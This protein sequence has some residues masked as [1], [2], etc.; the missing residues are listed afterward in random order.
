[1]PW[2]VGGIGLARRSGLLLIVAL[3]LFLFGQTSLLAVE[4]SPDERQASPTVPAKFAVLAFR[5]KPETI[6]RW[7]PIVDYLNQAG[8]SRRIELA[9]YTYKE[10]E[11][12]VA[13]KEVDFVLTQPS[14]YIILTYAQGLHSPL[15]TLVEID[16]GQEMR[17]FGGVIVTRADRE[18]L[19]SL[20]DLR[21]KKLVTSAK[22][23]LGSYQM[24][25]GEM[26]RR[27]I[28]VV[29]EMQV[30]EIGQP[31]DKSIKAVLSGEADVAFVRTGL[32]ESMSREGKLCCLDTALPGVAVVRHA[33]D[34]G[35]FFTRGGVSHSRH[36]AW[37]R[38]SQ[39][40]AH[41]RFYH[42]RRLPPGG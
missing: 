6:T 25:A 39:G 32:L 15:A 5:P 18:D 27:G 4:S 12:A 26:L 3:L 42:P 10:L 2:S 40:G 21:D 11:A 28:R 20:V 9:V 34:A 17:V 7:Q 22:S 16:D 31:Q 41:S 24:Q 14:H 36:A 37:W 19:N 1:M 38:S 33:L 8:L 29:D 35:G 13:A 23:S 30:T